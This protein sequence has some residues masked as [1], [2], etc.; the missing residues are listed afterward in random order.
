[1]FI[2]D[3]M[4]KLIVEVGMELDKNLIYYHDMLIKHGLYLSFA[5]V[6]HD[7]YYTKENLDG[8]TENQMKNACV[9]LRKLDGII[10]VN[11]DQQTT[12]E[13]I[14]AQ[15]QELLDKG[16]SKVF[17]TIKLDFQYKKADWYNYIQ[18]QDI[19]DVGLLVYWENKKFYHLPLD[20]QRKELL[21]ELN[22]YG[23]NFKESD[24]GVDKLRT[25]YYHKKMYSKNQNG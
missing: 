25:L 15:E 11:K 21:N 18:L 7:I 17:D 20:E 3:N 4:S 6:T 13:E 16:Y 12:D 8:L 22:S 23:F 10:G 5:C 14:K 1:M 24:L 19:K 2:G 9:R